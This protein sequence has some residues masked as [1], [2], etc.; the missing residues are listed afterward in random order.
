MA[1]PGQYSG[2]ATDQS[3][4]AFFSPLNPNNGSEISG[5]LPGFLI[6]NIIAR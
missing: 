1:M 5:T 2:L 3:S 4:P 6:I